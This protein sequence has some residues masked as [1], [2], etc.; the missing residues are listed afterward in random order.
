MNW[1]AIRVFGFLH[2][3]VKAGSGLLGDR[4]RHHPQ[5]TPVRFSE[6]SLTSLSERRLRNPTPHCVTV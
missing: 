2:P 3:K 5:L 1:T 4:R 6:A